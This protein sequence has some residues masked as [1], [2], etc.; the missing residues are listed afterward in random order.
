MPLALLTI[1]LLLS[2]IL[3]ISGIAKLLDPVGSL[4]ALTGFRV[5]LWL[6]KP[7]SRLLPLTELLISIAILRSVWAIGATWGALGLFLL[8]SVAITTALARG[9]R[10]DCHCF[11]QL[12]SEPV[13]LSTLARNLVLAALCGTVI[14]LGPGAS[15]LSW[16]NRLNPAETAVFAVLLFAVAVLVF[17]AWLMFQMLRQNGRILNRL[18]VLEAGGKK[19]PEPP[20]PPAGLPVGTTAPSFA[21]ESLGGE[22]VSLA[23]LL[24]VARPLLLVFGD[25]NCAPCAALLP[26]I[27][28]WD[29]GANKSFSLVLVSRGTVEANQKYLAKHKIAQV[30]LQKDREVAEAYKAE[31]TPTAVLIL[32]DGT[33]GSAVATGAEDIR[34]LMTQA[35][36]ARLSNVVLKQGAVAPI[37]TLPDVDGNLVANSEFRGKP[38]VFLFW[39]PGCGFCQKMLPDL[40]TWESEQAGGG[41]Q[42]V[43]ISAGLA[44]AHRA[45]GLRARILL[46]DGSTIGRVFNAHGTPTGVLLDAQ[47]RLSSE[48]AVGA[49]AVLGL[50]RSS[51]QAA[52]TNA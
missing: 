18:D 15:A 36:N 10:P 35:L 40:K 34:K 25:P 48:V 4:A 12:H 14:W 21:L 11:G 50:V 41:P 3:A 26:E 24:E 9:E 1:R 28:R 33:I 20:P 7:S 17:L 30:L 51:L 32:A 19:A 47:G 31:A 43:L 22:S 16:M 8:F 49:E 46:D 39:N 27:A 42:L 38:L 6:A 45:Y 52:A 2:S 37:F 29:I 44:N 13:G 5:P 23:D